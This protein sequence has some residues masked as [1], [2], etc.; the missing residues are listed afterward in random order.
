MK[1]FLIVL[2]LLL[3]TT[4]WGEITHAYFGDSTQNSLLNSFSTS[5]CRAIIK[6]TLKYLYTASSGDTVTEM[7]LYGSSGG[8]GD[9]TICLAIYTVSGGVPVTMVG[10]PVK[11]ATPYASG[12]TKYSATGLSIPLA[13]GTK[14]CIACGSAIGDP[15]GYYENIATGARSNHTAS[16]TLPAT[17][18]EGS[19]SSYIY[20]MWAVVTGHTADGSTDGPPTYLHG[21]DAVGQRHGPDGLSSRHEP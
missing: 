10:S 9:D 12:G 13:S 19:T 21:P 15:K 2:L 17:W 7:H 8:G 11:I 4:A 3:A 6:D 16:G 1:Y 18:V 20:S 14:Y 5:E